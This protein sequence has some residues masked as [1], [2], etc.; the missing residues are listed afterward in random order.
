[1]LS[2]A[3]FVKPAPTPKIPIIEEPKIP[4]NILTSSKEPIIP[5]EKKKKSQKKAP[6]SIEE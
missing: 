2:S 3:S 4:E 5:V 6:Q 1:M